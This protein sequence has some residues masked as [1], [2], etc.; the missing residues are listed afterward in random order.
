MFLVRQIKSR[1]KKLEETYTK[2]EK[3]NFPDKQQKANALE[4]LY[5]QEGRNYDLEKISVKKSKKKDKKSG[6][7]Y[8]GK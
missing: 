5:K 1:F 8:G 6:V 2:W 3:Q 4:I 7:K